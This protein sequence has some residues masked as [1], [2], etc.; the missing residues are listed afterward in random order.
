MADSA[1]RVVNCIHTDRTSGFRISIFT[2]RTFFGSYDIGMFGINETIECLVCQ[3]R[4]LSNLETC[5]GG[6][7]SSV[8]AVPAVAFGRAVPPKR[9]DAEDQRGPT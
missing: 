3:Y 4:P 7:L 6:C 9:R 1:P 5:N 8:A 2:L